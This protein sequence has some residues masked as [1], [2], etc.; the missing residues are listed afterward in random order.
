MVVSKGLTWKDG[1]EFIVVYK[2]KSI[3]EFKNR[4]TGE[5]KSMCRKSFEEY[6]SG[7]RN[8]VDKD[9]VFKLKK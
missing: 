2:D 7:F 1:D 6:V 5:F 3:V 4:T 8:W 9:G